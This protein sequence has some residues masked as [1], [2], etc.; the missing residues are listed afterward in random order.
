MCR[1]SP[2]TG[3]PAIF[4]CIFWLRSPSATAP[5]TRATS[6]VGRERSSIIVLTD[7]RLDLPGAL[8]AARVGAVGQAA[9][10]ADHRGDA[11]HLVGRALAGLG[12]VVER[13]A[14]LADDPALAGVEPDADLAPGRGAE[15][16]EQ[17]LQIGGGDDGAVSV[18]L[19]GA[20]G[21]ASR[22]LSGL[23]GHRAFLSWT[24]FRPG[25]CRGRS[26]RSCRILGQ[27]PGSYKF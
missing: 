22:T 7:S 5:I 23:C 21:G 24:C 2:L 9:L 20:C 4:S 17:R 3:R 1:N 18:R 6:R 27:G 15:R 11:N 12:E 14:E 26:S 16:L 13:L 10:A 25:R 8:G 19:G